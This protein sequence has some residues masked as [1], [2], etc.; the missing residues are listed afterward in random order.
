MTSNMN[1]YITTF[2]TEVPLKIT[3][4]NFFFVDGVRKFRHLFL[5]NDYVLCTKRKISA[6]YIVQC[7]FAN[8]NLFTIN[9][10]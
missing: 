2:T 4:I 8:H 10:V 7:H 5:F 1:V 3:L 9:F 6:R